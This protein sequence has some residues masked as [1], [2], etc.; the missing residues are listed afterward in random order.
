MAKRIAIVTLLFCGQGLTNVR[1]E[2][3]MGCAA[4][5]IVPAGFI[6]AELPVYG[7]ARFLG[8]GVFLAVVLP[9]ADRAQNQGVGR[10]QCLIA[11]ARAPVAGVQGFPLRKMDG[12]RGCGITRGRLQRSVA[13]LATGYRPRWWSELLLP[14]AV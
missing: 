2:A 3:G 1:E 14:L 13:A 11:A 8:V 12:K 6:E 9:P 7:Q 10:I 5:G 4:L